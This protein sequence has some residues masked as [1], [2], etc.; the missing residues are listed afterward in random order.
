[1]FHFFNEHY[2]SM[3]SQ[4]YFSMIVVIIL[5]MII[6]VERYT[7][8]KILQE[9]IDTIERLNSYNTLLKATNRL[10]KDRLDRTR[11]LI[12]EY[13][14][15]ALIPEEEDYDITQRIN[16][17]LYTKYQTSINLAIHTLLGTRTKAGQEALEILRE[18][19]GKTQ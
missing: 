9:E 16:K 18:I 4:N 6:F 19:A 10:L 13:N 14:K 1:M 5:V 7:H 12:D 15:K 8:N 3:I 11:K 17:D 2:F